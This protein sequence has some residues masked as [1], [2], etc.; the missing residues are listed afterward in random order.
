MREGGRSYLL[1]LGMNVETG[2]AELGNFLRQQLDAIDRI[3]KDDGLVDLQ[4]CGR[5]G[6]REGGQKKKVGRWEM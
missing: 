2:V 5:E 3:A 4:L 1:H 6:G